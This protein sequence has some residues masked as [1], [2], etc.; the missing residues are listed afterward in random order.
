MKS[1]IEKKLNIKGKV[2]KMYKMLNANAKEFKPESERNMKIVREEKEIK[3]KML[4]YYESL[5]RTLFD[6]LDWGDCIE[7]EY[8]TLMKV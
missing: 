4:K 2:R 7:M 8:K 5:R 3:E 1:V 6:D